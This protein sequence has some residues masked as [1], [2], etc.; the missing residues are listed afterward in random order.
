MSYVNTK[1]KEI[2]EAK[3]ILAANPNTTF[4]NMGWTNEM[5]SDLGYAELNFPEILSP[6]P[7]E[8]LVE[9]TPVKAKDGKWYRSFTT[10]EVSDGVKEELLTKQWHEV[11]IQR[12]NLLLEC[13]WT[14]LEDAPVNKEDWATYRQTLRD[15]TETTT[16]PFNVNW[17]NPPEA[18]KRT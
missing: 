9:G 12:S 11:R 13:D 14:Q 3:D 5:L 17:P 10:E 1:T 16:D 4:P 15:I 7:F 6:G 2:V 18:V 8:T